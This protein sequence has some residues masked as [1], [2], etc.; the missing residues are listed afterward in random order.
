MKVIWKYLLLGIL[1]GVFNSLF[2]LNYWDTN[3][4]LSNI[5]LYLSFGTPL[6]TVPMLTEMTI[7]FFP[8]IIFQILTGILFYKHFCT[9]SIY[10]FSRCENRGKWF[11]KEAFNVLINTLIYCGMLMCSSVFLA[12]INNNVTVSSK[13]MWLCFSYLLIYSCWLY[14][15]IVVINLV[16][17]ISSNSCYG[18][19]L[20]MFFQFAC[21]WLLL[22]WGN[23]YKII[24]EQYQTKMFT[25][26]KLNPV[27]HLVLGWHTSIWSNLNDKINYWNQNFLLINSIVILI[28]ISIIVTFVGIKLI[29]KKQIIN[30]AVEGDK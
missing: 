6:L 4:D 23:V 8:Y 2:Y 18:F 16:N 13:S 24:Q 29:G 10:I 7:K 12:S 22:I 27:S 9:A 26:L 15:T 14:I 21:I 3:L 11:L 25:L 20:V 1:V 28:I 17:I 5:I 30:S 19:I